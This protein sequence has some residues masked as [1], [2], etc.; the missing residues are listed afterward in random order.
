[1]QHEV[2]T[3]AVVAFTQCQR[4]VYYLLRGEQSSRAH[5]LELA[6]KSR[7]A[8]TRSTYLNGLESNMIQQL[9]F[10]V[11]ADLQFKVSADDLIAQCDAITQANGRSVRS[12]SEREPHLVVGTSTVS[13]EQQL[14]A[15]YAGHVIGQIDG[16]APSF[17][18]VVPFG[19]ER[20]RANLTVLYPQI[21]SIVEAI[22]KMSI[23]SAAE[24]PLLL[25]AACATCQFR[26]HCY[27]EAE[28][29]DNLTLLHRM[30][31]AL[32][33]K[34]ARRG[35]FTVNQLSYM[36]R[37]RRAKKR[38]AVAP[39]M[40][41][42]ELQALAIR[43]KKTYLH[44][45]PTLSGRPVELYLD[46]EGIPDQNFNYL[47]GLLI[48]DHDGVTMKAFWADT[49]A[50]E[51]RIFQ[52]CIDTINTF[53][54]DIPVYHY[55]SYEPRAFQSTKDAYGIKCDTVMKRLVNINSMIYGKIYFPT[56][57][58]RLKDLGAHAGATWSIS[59][60]T[61]LQSVAWRFLWEDTNDEKYKQ[62]ILT[63]NREDREA[64]LKVT[65]ELQN[66]SDFARERP[67]VD[68]PTNS[69]R[70]TTKAGSEIHTTFE[71]ILKSAHMKYQN[72]R[73]TLRSRA[74]ELQAEKTP[75]NKQ[76]RP[77]VRRTPSGRV[78]KIIPVARKR[79]CT[80]CN[81]QTLRRSKKVTEHSLVEL[82]RT[83][84]GCK[85]VLVKYVGHQAFCPSCTYY[86]SPPAIKR[87]RGQLFGRSIK[88]W[89][90]HFRIV[91]R[92]PIRVISDLFDTLISEYVPPSSVSDFI[93][94]ISSE[95]A[96]TEALLQTQ[97]LA[98]KYLHVD[99][100]TINVRGVNCYA[101]VLTDGRHVV[102]KFS[103][104]RQISA[105]EGLLA[106]YSGVLV[107]DFYGAYDS[108]PCRQ[109]RCLV[110][111]IRDLNDDLWKNPFN[112]EYERFVSDIRDI[113][114]PIFDDVGKHGLKSWY[115]KK[116]L[117]SVD[118]MYQNVI[119]CADSCSEL[120][121]K[122]KK[123]FVRYRESM[124]RFLTEDGIPW[125]NNMAER[126]LR[127][128]CVQQKISG[129]FVGQ[130]GADNYLRLL[131]I[132]QTCRFQEK[133]FLDLLLSGERDIDQFNPVRKRRKTGK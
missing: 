69:K 133:P 38:S 110:H 120:V 113:F 30:T 77:A 97:L 29:T 44:E 23:H 117:K 126:A 39:T 10:S 25:C 85:K 108:L 114:V 61:G 94:E 70:N 27:R 36:F 45:A 125:N 17:G 131:A 76:R 98:S 26:D 3:D 75:T 84:T 35:V 9:P 130:T 93:E 67:D 73:I 71:Q 91:L 132:A 49:A 112:E 11:D 28:E 13:K 83:K 122:Y 79:K 58:N 66:L 19:G 107:S 24:P 37:P 119:E 99:E 111:L 2:T 31:P 20:K 65:R 62:L 15:A 42:I 115:L 124:F 95:Y 48:K 60:S 86:Y 118:H 5:D 74:A 89:A 57:S 123:R 43:N 88:C 4:K 103:E 6:L 78:N 105:V 54:S 46:I 41:N 56:R 92:L 96:V 82:E 68:V 128:L 72:K 90:A 22:R 109:Q 106:D 100:T 121:E 7:A 8:A 127:H 32:M 52:E 55:G 34:Y 104:G 18:I 50:D 53:P 101:W 16:I 51:S 64:T 12:R 21:R 59:N 40:F 33:K 81:T 63:Y 1:M 80:H 87:L 116:H 47:I 102:F 14:A 129:C